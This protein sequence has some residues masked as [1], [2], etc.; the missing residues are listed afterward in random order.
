MTTTSSHRRCPRTPVDLMYVAS[1][2]T[3]GLRQADAEMLSALSELGV[4]VLAV[5]AS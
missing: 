1:G 4:D 5:S 2:T 3:A